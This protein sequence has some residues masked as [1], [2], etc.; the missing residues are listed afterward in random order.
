MSDSHKGQLNAIKA[1]FPNIIRLRCAFHLYQNIQKKV[2]DFK[3]KPMI[4]YILWVTKTLKEAKTKDEFYLIWGL[5]KPELLDKTSNSDFVKGF[6]DDYVFSESI[7]YNGG[8][9]LGKQKCNNSLEAMNRY[10]KDHW[11]DRR[12]RSVL[13]FFRIME[14]CMKHYSDKCLEETCMPADL[15]SL[16]EYYTKAQTILTKHL[17]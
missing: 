16:K 2:R 5:L 17:I 15:P 9:F 3:L 13:E 12:S 7:W 8:S 11:T 4:E 1:I 10:L 6:E 14:K